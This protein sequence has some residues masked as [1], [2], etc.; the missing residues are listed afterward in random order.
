MNPAF[1]GLEHTKRRLGS[2]DPSAQ[3]KSRWR[4]GGCIGLVGGSIDCFEPLF[5]LGV[6]SAEG[7]LPGGKE[8][9]NNFCQE[10]VGRE[11]WVPF[12]CI[13]LALSID[14]GAVCLRPKMTKLKNSPRP[15]HPT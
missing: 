10:S 5:S 7:G 13:F 1:R 9:C 8:I 15:A 12:D 2:I 6:W 11:L 14:I 3:G 4:L